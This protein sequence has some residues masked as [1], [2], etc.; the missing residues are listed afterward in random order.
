M[1]DKQKSLNDPLAKHPGTGADAAPGYEAIVDIWDG[2]RY[3]DSAFVRDGKWTYTMPALENGTHR[4]KA[5]VRDVE[6]PA[7]VF[8][9]NTFNMDTTPMILNG[10][11]VTASLTLSGDDVSDNAKSRVPTGGVL[12]YT[13]L[14][15]APNV[16]TVSPAGKVT[17]MGNGSTTITV[18]DARGTEISYS[19]TVSN[20]YR[21][22]E[23]QGP[24]NYNTA[25]D[26]I[27]SQ[28][29]SIVPDR[30]QM[31]V[32]LNAINTKYSENWS[33]GCPHWYG[34]SLNQS[35]PFGFVHTNGRGLNHAWNSSQAE[36]KGAVCFVLT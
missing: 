16:A 22:I 19:V 7:W 12:P 1:I 4:I 36:V 31:D 8:D 20:V 34:P 3:V 10:T 14:S 33:T 23:S 6:S 35:N 2:D 25:L 29:R 28:P 32:F 27:R 24:F 9:V 17:G 13:Y 30:P 5:T 21:L 15:S 11:A 18:S 26:W